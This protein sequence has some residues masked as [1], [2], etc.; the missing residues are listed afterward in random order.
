MKFD[1]GPD[2]PGAKYNHWEL[3]GVPLRIELGPKE[4][5]QQ[6]CSIAR[7]TER[8]RSQVALAD[9]EKE[10]KRQA[11]AV[12]MDIEK[13]ALTYFKNNIRSAENLEDLKKVLREHRGFV[14]IPYCHMSKQG[15]ACSDKLQKETEGAVVCGT[16]YPQ[17]EKVK[18]GQKCVLCSQAAHHLVY[19]AK[20]Y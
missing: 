18:A 19:V 5:E 9:V 8:K 1:N 17:E 15:E 14:K 7:R 2:S 4:V 20:T 11:N 10:V 3:H 16:L 13:R 6:V 12:D